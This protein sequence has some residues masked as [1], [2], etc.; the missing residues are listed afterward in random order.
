MRNEVFVFFIIFSMLSSATLASKILVQRGDRNLL[1]RPE[2]V[3]GRNVPRRKQL[4]ALASFSNPENRLE[5][6]LHPHNISTLSGQ[7]AHFDDGKFSR[8]AARR[9]TLFSRLVTA[10]SVQGCT[11]QGAAVHKGR[12]CSSLAQRG[13]FSKG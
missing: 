5:I 8:N 3:S 6:T 7:E 11:A 1:C 9:G 10:R 4:A 2:R 13:S 12:A